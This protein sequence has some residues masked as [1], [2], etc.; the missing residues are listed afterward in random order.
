MRKL[1]PLMNIESSEEA[2]LAK[3]VHQLKRRT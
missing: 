1:N 2:V 3:L